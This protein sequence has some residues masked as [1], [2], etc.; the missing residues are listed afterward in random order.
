MRDA[1]MAYTTAPVYTAGRPDKFAASWAKGFWEGAKHEFLGK[2]DVAAEYIRSGGGFGFVGE[3]R[4]ASLAKSGLFKK[5]VVKKSSDIVSSPFKL[6]E[7]ISATIELAPR[8]GTF[9]RAKMT[10]MTQKDAALTARQS[11]IDFNRGGTWTKVVNQFVPF[12]NARVQ[13]RVTLAQALK[14]NPK[15][16]LTKAFVAVGMPGMGAYAW[17]RLYHSELYDDIPEYIRQN[18]FTIITGT[19]KDKKGKISP[20][21]V[22]ISK[23][24]LGQMAWNPLEFGLDQM[25]E[26]DREGTTKFL[27]NYLSD[28]SPV[29]FAREGKVSVSKAA[30]SL[31]PPIVK[32]FA[33]DWANLKFYTGR[34]I[35]P[36]YMGKSKPP[37]L[38]YHENTPETYKWLGKKLKIAPL[39]LQNFASN[40]LAGYG[41]EGMDPSAMLRGLTGRLIKTTGGAKEDQAWK[42][43]ADIEHGYTEIR[44][45]AEE[46]I[47]NGE[48][49]AART[50]LNEWNKGLA[51]QISEYNK[52]FAE[53]GFEDEGGLRRSY[54]FTPR[55][56]KNLF[57]RREDDRSA[58]EKR[59]S[60][61]R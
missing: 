54:M 5:G 10:G 41:R 45:F 9:E 38:Q 21:Y 20:E 37:E 61:R 23:G 6:I 1:F 48:Q 18:Y 42:A 26:K 29:E 57:I 39:R 43:I 4:K 53:Y 3:L 35:V 59:L 46:L 13:G 49:D 31:T 51:S 17:N 58:I 56:Y 36:H 24:D 11:T 15:E 40:I 32:G 25:W 52:R 19:H 22:V 7:K 8:L 28:L 30:G 55:K 12:L 16:T 2:S 50:L 47:K 44:A 33:E 27:V 14:N 60:G 34:E